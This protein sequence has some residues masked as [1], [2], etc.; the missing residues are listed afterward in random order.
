M[1]LIFKRKDRFDRFH[2]PDGLS[3]TSWI[4]KLYFRVILQLEQSHQ[5]LANYQIMDVL[6]L[7]FLIEW[8]I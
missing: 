5:Q 7:W 1:T 8:F 2:L 3:S 4:M 6:T